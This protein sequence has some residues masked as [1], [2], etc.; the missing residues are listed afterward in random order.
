MIN[1]VSECM[2]VNNVLYSLKIGITKISEDI[3][4][5]K[6]DNDTI[7][8][9]RRDKIWGNQKVY[10]TWS[11]CI[12]KK[13]YNDIMDYND[14]MKEETLKKFKQDREEYFKKAKRNQIIEI[15]KKFKRKAKKTIKIDTYEMEIILLEYDDFM[16]LYSLTDIK[17]RTLKTVQK[18]LYNLQNLLIEIRAIVKRN[19]K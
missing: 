6:L 14:R 7:F 4:V 19:R 1:E 13:V 3:T 12:P 9:Y 8:V 5:N 17:V 2:K 10:S 11:G 16:N 15:L 18:E